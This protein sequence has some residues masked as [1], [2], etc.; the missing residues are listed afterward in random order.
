MQSLARLSVDENA[1]RVESIAARTLAEMTSTPAGF[2][3]SLTTT[4]NDLWRFFKAAIWTRRAH[5]LDER[6]SKK[7]GTGEGRTI[8]IGGCSQSLQGNSY[9]SFHTICSV[10]FRLDV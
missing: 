1:L 5:L 10:D 6:E 4:K 8:L 2:S 7:M 9:V 3:V